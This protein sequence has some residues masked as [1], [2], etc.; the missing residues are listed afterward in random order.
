[1]ARCVRLQIAKFT[2]ILPHP[3]NGLEIFALKGYSGA[4][5]RADA[6][7]WGLAMASQSVAGL[8]LP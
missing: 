1:M 4:L 3:S 7:L 5:R 2:D 6:F 8:P